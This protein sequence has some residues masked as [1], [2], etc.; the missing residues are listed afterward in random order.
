MQLVADAF[1][2]VQ[3]NTIASNALLKKFRAAAASV[4][5]A[6]S[7]SLKPTSRSCCASLSVMAAAS[8]LSFTR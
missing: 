8:V 1:G 5:S 2:D 7:P 6:I 4:M 3:V